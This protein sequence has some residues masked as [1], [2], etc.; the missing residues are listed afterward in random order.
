MTNKIQI[1]EEELRTTRLNRQD[2]RVARYNGKKSENGMETHCLES[3]LTKTRAGRRQQRK[4]SGKI[5]ETGRVTPG[6]PK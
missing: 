5:G 1:D 3:K 2:K 4:E 6:N